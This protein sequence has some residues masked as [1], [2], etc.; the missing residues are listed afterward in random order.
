MKRICSLLPFMFVSAVLIGC[1]GTSSLSNS[2]SSMGA[3]TVMAPTGN[4]VFGSAIHYVAN[5]TSGCPQGVARMAVYTAGSDPAYQVQGGSL[6]TTISLSPG[7]Y[8]TTVQAWDNCGGTAAAKVNFSLKSQ[9]GASV[10]V[11]SPAGNAVLGSSVH[12]VATATTNCPSGVGSLS[13]YTTPDHLAYQSMGGKLDAVLTLPPGTYNTSVKESDNC[14]GTASA[15]VSFNVQEQGTG[16]VSVSAPTFNNIYGTSVHYTATAT[17]TCPQGVSSMGIYPSSNQLAYQVQGSKLDAVLTLSPGTYDTVVQEWDNC[18]G[19]AVGHVPLTVQAPTTTLSDQT[20]NNTSAANSFLS[21]SN[22]N[23]GATNVSKVDIHTLLYSGNNTEIYAELQPWFGDPRHMQVG[24]TSWDP[25]QVSK[26]LND[27]VSRG[28]TGVVIDWYGPADAT[29]PTTLAWLA[30][31]EAHPGFKVIIMIDKGAV[32][33]SPCP[34]CNPQQTM[35]YLTNYVLDNYAT[36]PAY[37]RLNGNPIIT[38]FDLDLHY[39][40]DWNA[41]QAATSPNIAW[42]FENPDGF[43]HTITSGS[44]SWMN[45]TSTQYGMDYLTNFYNA[46]MQAQQKMAWGAGY[47]GFNDTLASWGLG[48]VVGQQCGQTWLET[49]SK[50]NSYYSSGMQLPILQLVTWNDYEEGTEMESGIDNCLTVSASLVGS[51]L[52][53]SVS[54]DESTVDHYAIYYTLDG[55]N[56]YSINTAAVGSRSIDLSSYQLGAG[57]V[58]VQAVGKPSIKNQM[59]GPVKI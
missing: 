1:G 51:A 8:N 59:S 37:A 23:L 7:T 45:A 46:A 28:A 2:T 25:A 18:G 4:T 44:Y 49:F 19:T 14:Q 39:T 53:W 56:L 29:E 47:K 10:R 33:I 41:I 11:T 54:G 17:T 48:R 34:G 24:Y 27:M 9:S 6:D 55:Q 26:Q 35:I 3:I 16:S 32:S 12:Y 58:Y 31:A 21:Q 40:L 50:I 42:I 43:T 15:S 5:A 38:E 13:I 20:S 30:A 36:S 22:G 57:T 52:Q